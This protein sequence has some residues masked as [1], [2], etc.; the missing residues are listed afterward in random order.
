MQVLIIRPTMV[1]NRLVTPGLLLD[2]DDIDARAL[3]Q[4]GYA[5]KLPQA[6][7]SAAAQAQ[8]KRRREGT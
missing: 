1:G 6:A 3:L 7:A 8:P 4:M 2:L 5:V